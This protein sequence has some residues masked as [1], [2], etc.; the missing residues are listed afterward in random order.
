[1]NTVKLPNTQETFDFLERL[2]DG[3]WFI[4]NEDMDY[5]WVAF[6]SDE[7]AQYVEEACP[8]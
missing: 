3:E 5:V 6:T 8:R 7:T 4:D 2:D 1:M